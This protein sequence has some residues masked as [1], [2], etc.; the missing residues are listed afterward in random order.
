MDSGTVK[1]FTDAAAQLL[2]ALVLLAAADPSQRTAEQDALIRQLRVAAAAVASALMETP[3][4]Q[5]KMPEFPRPPD[6][7]QAAPAPA[8]TA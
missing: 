2:P 4:P 8:Y 6:M 3:R 1:T 7:V 5:P